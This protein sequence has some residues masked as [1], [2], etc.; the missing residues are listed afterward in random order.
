MGMQENVKLH[1][2]LP[3]GHVSAQA[4]PRMKLLQSLA[5][6]NTRCDG[7]LGGLG[8]AP[9]RV[10]SRNLKVNGLLELPRWPQQTQW[11][12]FYMADCRWQLS[13]P[14]QSMANYPRTLTRCVHK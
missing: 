12:F 7:R 11:C 14:V 6:S 4:A 10:S 3:F 5:K 9:A 2:K 8:L 13:L 1:E